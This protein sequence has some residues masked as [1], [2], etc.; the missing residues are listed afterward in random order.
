MTDNYYCSDDF[1][2]ELNMWVPKPA[3][4]I[5]EVNYVNYVTK[6]NKE[7]SSQRGVSEQF[8]MEA[9]AWSCHERMSAPT[10]AAGCESE[11]LP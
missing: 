5:S 6:F 10:F 9:G 4:F 1:V 8:C 3:I 7:L 11:P 2:F